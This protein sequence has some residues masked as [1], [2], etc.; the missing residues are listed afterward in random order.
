MEQ[1]R[2]YPQGKTAGKYPERL[3]LSCGLVLMVELKLRETEEEESL[4]SK[5]RLYEAKEE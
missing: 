1:Q 4:R 5:Q 2:R 3:V